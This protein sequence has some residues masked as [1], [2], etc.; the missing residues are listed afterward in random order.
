VPKKVTKLIPR[1][2]SKKSTAADARVLINPRI[3]F[4]FKKKKINNN[5]NNRD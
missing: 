1:S 4:F 3:N 5:N 2:L